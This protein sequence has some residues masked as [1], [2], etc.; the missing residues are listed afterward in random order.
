MLTRRQFLAKSM[1]T[2]AG[3]SLAEWVL[4]PTSRAAEVLE[5]R[6]FKLH[7]RHV[8]SIAFVDLC[9]PNSGPGYSE[10]QLGFL[11]ALTKR[12]D[13]SASGSGLDLEADSQFP[14]EY[15]PR[16]EPPWLT[17]SSPS[18][19]KPLNGCAG[20]RGLAPLLPIH[21]VPMVSRQQ[22]TWCD[23]LQA[24]MPPPPSA[25]AAAGRATSAMRTGH[26]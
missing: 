15:A 9:P 5:S 12:A 23:R 7:D 1:A 11:P 18:V 24:G 25:A 6:R 20:L 4:V 2:A 22:S 21:A 10:T 26:S 13:C 17:M 8:L 19:S 14:D 16:S 3:V